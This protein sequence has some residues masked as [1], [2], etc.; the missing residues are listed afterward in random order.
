MS[1]IA[2]CLASTGFKLPIILEQT[3]HDIKPTDIQP[4][5]LLVVGLEDDG[6]WMRRIGEFHDRREGL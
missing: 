5:L 1:D 4:K 2:N 6:S 3:C